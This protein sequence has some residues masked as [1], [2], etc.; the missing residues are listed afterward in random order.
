MKA[1]CKT[2]T[3]PGAEYIET[4]VPFINKDELLIKIHHA[5]ICGSDVP[6]YGWTGWA[7]KRIKTPMVFGHELCGEVVEIGQLAKGFAKGDFVSIES[8]IFCGL[9][10]QC[11]N[12]QRH[13]C[14]NVRIIGIDCPGGFAEFAAAPARC[15]WKHTD[16]SLKQ[17]GSIMEP[18]G[19]A[20][21]ATLVEDIT[22]KSVLVSG[23]GPQGLFA[24]AIAKAGGAKL[25]IGLETSPFRQ[26]LAKKMGAD[27]VLDPRDKDI[28]DRIK[29]ITRPSDGM[30]AV[31][32]MSGNP[33]AI[34]LALKAARYGGRFTAFG[35][36]GKKIKVDYSNEIVFKGLTV[37]GIVGRE[38]FKTWYKME[39][40][41]KSRAVDPKPVITHVFKFKH[42]RKAFE[43]MS[44]KNKNCGKIVLVP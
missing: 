5:S 44:S 12:D 30:D 23:C 3:G 27:F 32:E 6:I 40:I 38:I 21:Y 10:Y 22:A 42:F 9:C 25:V 17:I 34:E 26:K 20:V 16:N 19:N 35:I 36:P 7:P 28:L 24:A 41:L 14:V 37:R 39:S 1:I 43:V 33:Q 15:A 18:F 8:H 31:L 11:R 29:R 2:K 13:V 4:D